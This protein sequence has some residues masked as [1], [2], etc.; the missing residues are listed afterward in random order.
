MKLSLEEWR[1]A[2]G[3]SQEEMAQ[4]CGVHVNTYRR[5]ETNPGEIRVDKAIAIA[6]F[7]NIP[8]DDIFFSSNIT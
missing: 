2:K 1:R 3:R 4:C 6:D 7:L 8:L 5:W